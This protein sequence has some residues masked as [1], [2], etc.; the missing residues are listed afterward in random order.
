VVVETT[1]R[2]PARSLTTG[3][4]EHLDG[5]DLHRRA[6]GGELVQRDRQYPLQRRRGDGSG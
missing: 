4:V 1:G 6:D 5:A 2:R 3:G